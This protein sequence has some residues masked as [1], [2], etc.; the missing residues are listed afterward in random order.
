MVVNGPFGYSVVGL[1][2]S[3]GLEVAPLDGRNRV[4]SSRVASTTTGGASPMLTADNKIVWTP[5]EADFQAT[6]E[7]QVHVTLEQGGE[8]V[9]RA[10]VS[11][12]KERVVIDRTLPLVEGTTFSDERGRYLLR[13]AKV[14]PSLPLA[15]GQMRLVELVDIAGSYQFPESV[16][17]IASCPSCI[18]LIGIRRALC[19]HMAAGNLVAV[20]NNLIA[21]NVQPINASNSFSHCMLKHETTDTRRHQDDPLRCVL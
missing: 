12:C 1:P 3:W 21:V 2:S 6:Q 16:T 8:S 11:V 13:V 19:S 4:L 20:D 5:N 10:R 15:A 7:L 9:L 17:S 18:A 14:D